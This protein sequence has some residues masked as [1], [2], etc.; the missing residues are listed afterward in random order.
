VTWDTSDAPASI[1]NKFSVVLDGSTFKLLVSPATPITDRLFPE[2]LVSGFDPRA[3]FVTVVVDSGIP[4][5]T[6]QLTRKHNVPS[7]RISRHSLGLS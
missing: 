6:Y 3:G 2:T 5:G 1:S 4:V 7:V